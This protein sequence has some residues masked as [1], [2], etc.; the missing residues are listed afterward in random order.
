M[1]VK[2]FLSGFV[3]KAFLTE[4]YVQ[5]CVGRLFPGLLL[6]QPVLPPECALKCDCY[7]VK[8]A[9]FWAALVTMRS[10]LTFSSFVGVSLS[11]RIIW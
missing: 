10:V 2:F 1:E 4:C 7:P 6:V 9:R 8:P 11:P 5:C 3:I